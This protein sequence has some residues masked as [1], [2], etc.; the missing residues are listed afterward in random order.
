MLD[1]AGVGRDGGVA[2][3]AAAVVT[4]WSR[5]RKIDVVVLAIYVGSLVTMGVYVR[6]IDH[7]SI[8]QVCNRVE[9]V[10][11]QLVIDKRAAD[12]RL[13]SLTTDLSPGVISAAHELN[14]KTIARFAPMECPKP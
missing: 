6:H 1:R 14:A 13:D 5:G 7:R 12:E 11:A 3:V 4:T 10:K 9:A 2:G 8:S